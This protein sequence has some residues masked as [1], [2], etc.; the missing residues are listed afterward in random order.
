M[1]DQH[2]RRFG[3][4]RRFSRKSVKL[5]SYVDNV[6]SIGGG[7]EA[8]ISSVPFSVSYQQKRSEDQWEVIRKP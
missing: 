7:T 4:H 5:L 1:S 6:I 3:I 8:D 2:S